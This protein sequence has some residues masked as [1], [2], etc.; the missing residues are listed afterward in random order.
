M[1]CAVQLLKT[2][3]LQGAG[4]VTLR[5][6]ADLQWARLVTIAKNLCYRVLAAPSVDSSFVC[7]SFFIWGT[8]VV[9]W[10]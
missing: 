3:W 10:M 7:P 8:L 1:R 4:F 9:V 2:N 6:N 5:L